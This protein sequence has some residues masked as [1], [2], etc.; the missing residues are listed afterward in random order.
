MGVVRIDDQLLKKVKLALKE[1]SNK[2][3]YGSV[4]ALIN[5]MIY[6]QLQKEKKVN[7]AK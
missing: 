1:E 2:Y 5:S 4:A 3:K 6:E 7:K